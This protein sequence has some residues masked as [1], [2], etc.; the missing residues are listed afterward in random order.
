MSEKAVDSLIIAA[1]VHVPISKQHL[2][3]IIIPPFP[4]RFI[5]ENMGFAPGGDKGEFRR[6]QYITAH[7]L[8]PP[9]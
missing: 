6:G 9:H 8:P 4:P 3:H 5:F 2:F 1:I 7:V